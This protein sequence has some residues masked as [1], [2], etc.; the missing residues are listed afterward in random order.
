M[1]VDDHVYPPSEDSYLLLDAI[2][3]IKAKKAL[4]IGC[5]CGIISIILS[6]SCKEVFA[7]DINKHACVNMIKNIKNNNLNNNIHILNSD[8]TAALRK[9]LR[10][11]LIVSNPPYIPVEKS[12]EEDVSWA[13]GIDNSLSKSLLENTLPH[14]SED[15]IMFL[16]QSSLSELSFLKRIIE[17]MG[18]TIEE[19]SSKEFFFE[20]I[21]VFKISRIN[22]V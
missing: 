15:G 12:I 21:I 11:D 18:F 19:V 14:L 8:I 10:F 7:I 1:C 2:K 20:R 3:N 22:P 5:G 9:D 6:R 17:D 16:V 13:A 4:E